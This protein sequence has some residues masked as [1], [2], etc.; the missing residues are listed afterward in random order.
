M[1][2]YIELCSQ[3]FLLT[4]A[5]LHMN[6]RC[7]AGVDGRFDCTKYIAESAGVKTSSPSDLASFF[8]DKGAGACIFKWGEK[9]SFIKTTDAEFRVPAFKIAVSDTTGC[10]DSYCGGFIAGLSLGYDLEAACKLG[11]ATS[12]LVATAL[13]S[14]AGVVD[15]ATTKQFI[16]ST[17]TI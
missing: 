13:G 11:T 9:G 14:D 16:E 7:A 12:G 6:M 4:F 3:Q 2:F 15:L 8:M 17:A 1:V 10:G 5:Y